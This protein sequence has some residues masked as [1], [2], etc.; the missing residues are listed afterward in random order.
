M[1]VGLCR[2]NQ[3]IAGNVSEKFIAAVTL[4]AGDRF[5]GGSTEVY[6]TML[7]G[8][9]PFLFCKVTLIFLVRN[10]IHSLKHARSPHDLFLVSIIS[11][12]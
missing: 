10:G 1:L 4:F 12:L 5:E 6:N 8:I 9:Y 7:C 11:F 2:G 3:A